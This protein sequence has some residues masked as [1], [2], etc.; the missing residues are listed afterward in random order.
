MLEVINHYKADTQNE[1][2]NLDAT[3]GVIFIL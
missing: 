2:E 1:N 3:H